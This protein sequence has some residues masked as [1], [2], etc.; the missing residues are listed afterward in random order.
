MKIMIFGDS[1]GGKSTFA[2]KLGKV[3]NI[4]VFHLDMLMGQLG[5]ENKDKILKTIKNI[6]GKESWIIEGNAFT[7][8]KTMRIEAA[9]CIYIFH[10]NRI[11]AFSNHLKRY[12]KIKFGIEIRSGSNNT[13]LNLKYFIPYIFV[14][15]PKRKQNAINFAE[16]LK[17]KIVFINNFKE[18]DKIINKLK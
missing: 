14:D 2:E 3:L 11:K 18:A 15:F 4:E 7:K 5:K 16:G 6:I 8:D 1:A 17:K 13:K 12:L 10:N 9:D